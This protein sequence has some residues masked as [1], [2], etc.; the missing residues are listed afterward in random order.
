MNVA[1]RGNWPVIS[2]AD[3][4]LLDVARRVQLSR[5]K[6]EAADRNF[7]ALCQYVDREGSPLFGRVVECYPSGSFAI[8]T[9]IASRVA[10]NQHDVDV[11]I[12]LD[13]A[14]ENDVIGILMRHHQEPLSP[15]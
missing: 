15:G 6:H 11:V 3:A 10:T 12:E 5:T 9:V 7:R 1:Q 2:D 14:P 13:V 4:L 8:G